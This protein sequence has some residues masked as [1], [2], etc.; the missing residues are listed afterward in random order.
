MSCW[1]TRGPLL[2]TVKQK[3]LDLIRAGAIADDKLS[4]KGASGA[5]RT[6]ISRVGGGDINMVRVCVTMYHN[7]PDGRQVQTA[8]RCSIVNSRRCMYD[9]IFAVK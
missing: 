8:R 5:T 1:H 2:S 9:V 4:S 7:G 6:N 3:W